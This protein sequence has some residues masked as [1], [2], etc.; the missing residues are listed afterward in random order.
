MSGKPKERKLQRN[1]ILHLNPVAVMPGRYREGENNGYTFI[2]L[3]EESGSMAMTTI[4][5]SLLRELI[6]AVL[7]LVR[8]QSA[9]RSDAPVRPAA[10]PE[11]IPADEI[12]VREAAKA[13]APSGQSVLTIRVGDVPMS[14]YAPAEVWK[15][16]LEALIA[17]PNTNTVQ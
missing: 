15:E 1:T 6:P 2:A 13:G 14:F 7:S 12:S 3:V 9:P 8:M 4:R 10:I 11:A 17:N 16:V 5:P